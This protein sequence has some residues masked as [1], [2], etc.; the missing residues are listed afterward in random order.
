[1]RRAER[2]DITRRGRNYPVETLDESRHSERAIQQISDITDQTCSEI[3]TT[4]RTDQ[5]ID[6]ISMSDCMEQT[7]RITLNKLA[8][9]LLELSEIT[10]GQANLHLH[11]NLMHFPYNSI[12]K[13]AWS[14]NN[15]H[16]L[17]NINLWL[18]KRAVLPCILFY[19]DKSQQTIP[20]RKMEVSK[21]RIGFFC[22]M[23][24]FTSGESSHTSSEN[25]LRSKCSYKQ[26][27][28]FEM[29]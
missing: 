6:V 25:R 26:T 12:K 23:A 18:H 8:L 29:F 28:V 14:C 22:A 19:N 4:T 24:S 27:I 20:N 7:A 9:L 11:I 2:L 3:A 13:N 15:L 16:L 5:R 17:R 10:R 21:G 1:M